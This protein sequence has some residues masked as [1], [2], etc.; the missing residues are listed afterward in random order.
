[1]LIALLPGLFLDFKPSNY[2]DFI[3]MLGQQLGDTNLAN[4]LSAALLKDRSALASADAWRSFFIV[5]AAFV[6]VWLFM[7]KKTTA[8]VLIVGLGV[9]TLVDLWTVDKR[10]LNNDIFVDEHI[11]KT[12]F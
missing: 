8:T 3:A 5:A 9:L 10:Y 2:S 1:L 11:S 6:L 7:K 12:P 4:Q